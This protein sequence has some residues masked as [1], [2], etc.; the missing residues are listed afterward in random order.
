[1]TALMDFSLLPP[2]INSARMYAGAG[3]APMLAAA[4]AWKQLAAELRS[5][6][7][8]Y[9]SVVNTLVSDDW[10]GSS[11]TS[12]AAAAAPYVT[13]MNSSAA[14]AELTAAQAE[15]AAVAYH[16]AFAATVPPQLVATNRAQLKCLIATNVLGHNTPAI[17]AHEAQYAEMWA[18]DSAAMYGYAATSGSAT[19]LTPFTPPPPTTSPAAVAASDTA[20]HVAATAAAT[21]DAVL[22]QLVSAIPRALQGL[23]TGSIP[24]W[25]QDLWLQWGPNANVWNTLFSSGFL[26]PSNTIT[27]FLGML[28]NAAAANSAVDTATQAAAGAGGLGG[29]FA[30]PFR[31]VGAVGGVDGAVSASLAKAATIGRMS[32]PATWTAAAPS[33]RQLALAMGATPMIGPDSGPGNISG[34]PLGNVVGQGLGRAVP[35]YGFRPTVVA[36]PPAAG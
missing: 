19:Q 25:L 33:T 9:G 6:A 2:E 24:Q 4:T 36:R 10:Q 31:G 3:S 35:Q 21:Q 34:I 13:W 7:L 15:A 22:Q 14:R 27:P 28:G 5:A 23:A 17:A 30:G 12:M 8:S 11:A 1:M 20:A 26:V 29:A 18:Q 16:V 32:A